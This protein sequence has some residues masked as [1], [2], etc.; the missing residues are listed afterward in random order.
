MGHGRGIRKADIMRESEA[1][2]RR[3]RTDRIDLLQTHFDDGVTPPEETMAAYAELMAQ[4]KVRAVGASN[5]SPARIKDSLTASRKLGVARYESLQPLYNLYDRQQYEQEYEALAIA[6][7]LSVLTYWSLAAG[8]L[9]GKYRSLADAE[10]SKTRGGRVK[11]FLNPRGFAIL[12]ALDQVAAAHAAI[13]AQVALAW[14]MARPSVTAPIVSATNLDQL[15]DILKS[16]ELTLTG[17][18]IKALDQASA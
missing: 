15:S 12:A 11:A 3:L 2:L 18:D 10:K 16:A 4:G 9:T 6:E 1:S 14:L 8:F 5:V 17:D 13:P 7:K